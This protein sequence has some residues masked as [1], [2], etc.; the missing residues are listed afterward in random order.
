MVSPSNCGLHKQ[1]LLE[2]YDKEQSTETRD[3]HV[4]MEDSSLHSLRW[5]TSGV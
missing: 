3:H 2:D 1:K 4:S 5:I